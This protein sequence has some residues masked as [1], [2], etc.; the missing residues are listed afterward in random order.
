[1]LAWAFTLAETLEPL[2]ILHEDI[3]ILMGKLLPYEANSV[4]L[5]GKARRDLDLQIVGL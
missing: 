5:V 4:Q 1:M 3:P 2:R